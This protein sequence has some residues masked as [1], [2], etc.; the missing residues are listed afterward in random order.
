MPVKPN[1]NWVNLHQNINFTVERLYELWN[2][3]PDGSRPTDFLSAWNCGIN[4]IKA[5]LGEAQ[6]NNKKVRAYGGGWSLSDVQKTTD[7]FINTNPLNLIQ[8]GLKPPSVQN[9]IDGTRY[10][11]SQCGASIME[12]NEQLRIKQMALSTSGASDGQTIAGATGTCTHGSAF[13]FGAMPD[14][15]EAI[16]IIVSGTQHY[17]VEGNRGI[18]TDDFLAKYA[19]G[20]ARINNDDILN[21]AIVSFGSFGVVH[22][23]LLKG[24]PLYELIQYQNYFDWSVVQDSVSDPT[25]LAPFGLPFSD[26]YHFSLLV[27]PYKKSQVVVTAMQKA[28]YAGDATPPSSPGSLG[29][30]NDILHVIGKVTDIIPHSIPSI[31]KAMDKLLKKQYPIITTPVKSLPGWIFASGTSAG[32]GKGLSVEISVDV[33]YALAAAN[34][35]FDVC[36]TTPFPGLVAFRYVKKTKAV[37]GFT[38]YPLSCV[39]EFPAIYGTEA[40]K[41][42]DALYAAL[43]KKGI[44]FTSHWGQCNNLNSTN[45]RA[46][47]GNTA[48]EK[49]INAR[50]SLLQ[51]HDQQSMFTNDFMH[52]LGLDILSP[53]PSAPPLPLITV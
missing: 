40:L 34:V 8:V 53:G 10:C 2:R 46:K 45:V 15:V 9:G 29:P 51:T 27:N 48:I 33:T 24:E 44:E 35:I 4:N 12:I 17:W 49:W 30:S 22:A 19:P 52:R 32:Q 3:L 38:Q 23:L 6:T 14:F 47:Y 26:P 43:D 28:P 42:Y 7:Y 31:V 39:I 5:V 50:Y 37:L 25:S 41:F 11:L 18:V 20:A 1:Y 36:Q 13:K 21:S 16:H